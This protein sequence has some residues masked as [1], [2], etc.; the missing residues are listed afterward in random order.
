[1]VQAAYLHPDRCGDDQKKLRYWPIGGG[2]VREKVKSWPTS[3]PGAKRW[4]KAFGMSKKRNKPSPEEVAVALLAVLRLEK[5]RRF[6]EKNN[7]SEGEAERV[8]SGKKSKDDHTEKED[9]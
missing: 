6:A 4:T 1:V 3:T 2:R 5:I 8:L 9:A 7:I